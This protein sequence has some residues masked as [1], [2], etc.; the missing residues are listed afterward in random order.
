LYGCGVIVKYWMDMYCC[1]GYVWMDVAGWTVARPDVLA[2]A[3][4]SRLDETCRNRSKL[5]L[6]L[7]LRRRAF[8]WVRHN[9]AQAKEDRLSEDAW[10]LEARCCMCS[11]GE[12]PRFWARGILAEASSGSLK[13]EP[14]SLVGSPVDSLA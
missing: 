10:G 14:V 6:E 11:S 8:V 9:L 3:T 12:E 7:S 5:A 13:R 1:L 2:Q 4:Q